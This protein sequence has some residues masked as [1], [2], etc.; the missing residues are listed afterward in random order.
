MTFIKLFVYTVLLNIIRYFPGGF[1]ESI[2]IFEPMHKPMEEY[3]DCF[4]FTEADLRF[5]Y[6]YNFLLWLSVVLIFHISHRSLNGKMIFRSLIIFGICFLFFGSLAAIYM[7]HFVPG[8]R[9]FYIYSILDGLILFSLL[10]VINGFLYPLFF[11][12]ETR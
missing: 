6:A 5:S 1:I 12:H 2:T 4:G 7:N 11:K 9:S 3:P 8:I 10:G